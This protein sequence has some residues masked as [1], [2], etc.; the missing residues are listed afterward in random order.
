[1]K[2][3]KNLK[4][5][6]KPEKV[7]IHISLHNPGGKPYEKEALV[8]LGRTRLKRVKG[9]NLYKGE[10]LKGNYKIS[11]TANDMIAP[12]R[13]LEVTGRNEITPIYLGKKG[14]PSY[15][16]G[17]NRVPFQP[18]ESLVGFTFEIKPPSEKESKRAIDRVCKQFKLKPYKLKNEKGTNIAGDGAIWM[19]KLRNPKDLDKIRANAPKFLE[20]DV[21]VGIPVDLGKDQ[22]KLIDHRFV[23]RFKN[24]MKPKDINALVEKTGGRILRKFIQAGNAFLIEFLK[25]N[26]KSHLE[27]MESWYEKD[28]VK[29]A[30]PDIIAEITDDVFPADPP[31][32]ALY[33]TQANLTLQNADQAWQFLNGIDPNITLGSTNVTVCSLD[34]GIDIDHP[35]IGGN[36]TDG[37]PQLSQCFDFSG[38]QQCTVPGYTPFSDHGMG[39]YGIIA[40]LTDNNSAVAG[41]APNTH[42]I[43]LERVNVSSVNYGDILLWAAGFTTG[44]TTAGWPAEPIPNPA[45]IISCSHGSDGLALSGIMD[46]TFEYLSTYGRGGLGTLV[47]YS[48]G[49]GGQAIT[50]VRTFAAHPRTLA[51]SNS[52]QP[53]GAGV[54]VLRF[55]SN[56]GPEIDICAQGHDAPSLDDVGGTQTFG[57]TSAAAPTVAAAAA[58]MLSVEPQLT[59]IN[60]RDILRNTAVV[61]DGANVDPVGQWVGGFSQ[62]YGFG[63]LDILAAVQAANDFDT[64]AV[65]LVIRDNL[66]DDGSVVP[67]GGTFWRSPDI[68]IRNADPA[69]EGLADPAYGVNPP[70]QNA[71]SGSDNWVRVRVK[72]AGTTA[73]SNFY[74]RLYL[75]HFAGSQFVYPTD[76]IPTG[77]PGDPIPNPLVQGTYLIGEEF[78]TTQASG[79][80]IIYDFQWPAAMVPPE[81]V[82]ATS[83][84]PC[85]LAEVSPHT[86]PTPSGNLVIDNSNLGQRNITIDYTDDSTDDT[87]EATGVVGNAEDKSTMKRLVLH[88]GKLPKK[89]AI[90]IRFLDERV[91]KTVL[92]LLR[93]NPSYREYNELLMIEQNACKK[94]NAKVK[95]KNG[96]TYFY[97]R[98][99]RLIINV[100]MINGRLTPVVIGTEFSDKPGKDGI[101]L[102]LIEENMSSLQ[103]GGFGL[104]LEAER[105]K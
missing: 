38:M 50:G 9:K 105:P 46:D 31:N 15:R 54:E 72:N 35:D 14:W 34:R 24:H 6:K 51:I 60:L 66:S 63:R 13:M 77:N 57:G 70:N 82:G 86:G 69:V 8:R 62:W 36:L 53:N 100:P 3:K 68:W 49:N 78:V 58:L 83:W 23:V 10:M 95:S 43:G 27:L 20:R 25:G 98:E 67:T 90:W 88:K 48:A 101:E 18:E 102:V 37:N 40:A 32:D 89:S 65:N 92:E 87:Y 1:M 41:I 45:D 33:G 94:A 73:S 12:P 4:N 2:S 42:Q 79:D 17:Q 44:N 80:E 81:T 21:R 5:L 30:E 59:W 11:V 47:V 104:R 96:Q 19:F 29:Y 64:G 7:S 71:I 28:I 91:E 26:W 16:M 103:L 22:I 74:V 52:L 76:F 75:S 56:F 99:S 97:T 61:I 55:T 85:L 93:K 84:H 39:V